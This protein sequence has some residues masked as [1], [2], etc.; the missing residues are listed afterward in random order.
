ML[1]GSCKK[2]MLVFCLSVLAF[3]IRLRFPLMRMNLWN[4]REPYLTAML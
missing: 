1:N 3:N 2:G 4:W